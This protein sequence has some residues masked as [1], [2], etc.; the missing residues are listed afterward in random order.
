[1]SYSRFAESDIS[2]T[3]QIQRAWFLSQAHMR[4]IERQ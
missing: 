2:D 1:L 4:R 3:P